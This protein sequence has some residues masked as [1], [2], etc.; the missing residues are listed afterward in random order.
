MECLEFPAHVPLFLIQPDVK[1]RTILVQGAQ[2]RSGREI[3]MFFILL[4]LFKKISALCQRRT[5]LTVKT[6]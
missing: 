6:R 4:V 1:R 2:K 3:E 5:R